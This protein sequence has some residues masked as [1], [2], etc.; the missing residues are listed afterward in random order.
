M[1]A[2]AQGQT[3]AVALLLSAG[4]RVDQ[5]DKVYRSIPSK[6]LLPVYG[7]QCSSFHTNECNVYC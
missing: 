5:Q 6:L 1:L 7:G 4:V 3:T 2:A